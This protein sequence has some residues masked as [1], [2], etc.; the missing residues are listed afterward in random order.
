VPLNQEVSVN[1]HEMI[2]L[3]SKVGRCAWNW[4]DFLFIFLFSF[5]VNLAH[6]FYYFGYVFVL[7][8]TCSTSS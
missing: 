8:L 6:F 5:I 2:T 7:S 3:L 1:G 4:I